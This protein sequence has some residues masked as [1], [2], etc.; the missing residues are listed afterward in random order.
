MN[1]TIKAKKA[2]LEAQRKEK[3]LL[4]PQILKCLG[5]R[6]DRFMYN[7]CKEMNLEQPFVATLFSKGEDL[8][9]I[10]IVVDI[11]GFDISDKK[12]I[13]CHD[14]GNFKDIPAKL[15]KVGNKYELS[16]EEDYRRVKLHGNKDFV[17]AII[18]GDDEVDMYIC[19]K[20]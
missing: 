7:D 4:W 18:D 13:I 17:I 2:I 10:K 20:S 5:K 16:E 6:L 3:P 9:L 11:E 1:N 15:E 19:K 14:C 8:L 12:Q